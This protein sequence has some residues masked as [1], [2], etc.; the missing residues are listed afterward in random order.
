MKRTLGNDSEQN[1]SIL[2]YVGVNL[3]FFQLLF[4]RI[5]TPSWEK[6]NKGSRV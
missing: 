2:T 3:Y 1:K 6:C 5:V 4:Y